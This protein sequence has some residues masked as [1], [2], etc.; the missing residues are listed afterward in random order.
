MKHLCGPGES[1]QICLKGDKLF[2]AGLLQ[3]HVAFDCFFGSVMSVIPV[4]L[5]ILGL[6]KVVVCYGYGSK[7][8]ALGT[9]GF[10]RHF[11]FSQPFFLGY[12]VFLTH[13]LMFLGLSASYPN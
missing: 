5:A 4:G 2:S 13:R 9:T 12:P 6:P 8:K 7:R 11:S 10:G 1:I 3:T